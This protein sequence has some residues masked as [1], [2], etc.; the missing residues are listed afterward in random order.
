MTRRPV[1]LVAC[2]AV[3]LTACGFGGA[4]CSRKA[5]DT[6][7][8]DLA[9]IEKLHRLEVAATLAASRRQKAAQPR[10]QVLTYVPDIKDV[11]VTGDWTFEWGNFT[12]SYV[13]AP[14]GAE[15]HI[16]GKLLRVLKKQGDGSWKAARGMWNTSN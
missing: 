5:A 12:A 6:H 11:T 4:G 3:A 16:R 10:M 15:K 14:G 2:A 9:G 7:A 13:E 1:T 8:Q